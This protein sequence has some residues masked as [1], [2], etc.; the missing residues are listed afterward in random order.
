MILLFLPFHLNIISFFFFNASFSLS[1]SYEA[2]LIAT[3]TS[4]TN[5]VTTTHHLLPQV[6]N[7]N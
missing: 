4:T 5:P 6:H 1:L 7:H 2:R 3:S